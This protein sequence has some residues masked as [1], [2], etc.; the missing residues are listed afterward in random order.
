MQD[1]RSRLEPRS[2]ACFVVL[3]ERMSCETAGTTSRTIAE[4]VFR[5]SSSLATR[6]VTLLLVKPTASRERRARSGH[7]RIRD[8]GQRRRARGCARR[9]IDRHTVR[10]DDSA[11]AI[12][13]PESMLAVTH[14]LFCRAVNALGVV[15]VAAD[16][17]AERA[18][19]PFK[20]L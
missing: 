16:R 17:V 11:S 5:I 20:V 1:A 18:Q 13:H 2:E 12:A 7:R 14:P 6:A 9:S 8:W 19:I 3:V 4:T 10:K 15:E